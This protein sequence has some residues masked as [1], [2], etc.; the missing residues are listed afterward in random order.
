MIA[1]TVHMVTVRI[2]PMAV[3]I[4]PRGCPPMMRVTIAI[5]FTITLM[6]LLG[7]GA[8][9]HL[10]LQILFVFV[11]FVMLVLRLHF[12]RGEETGGKE[13]ESGEQGFHGANR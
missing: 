11:V 4:I 6:T 5:V 10:I 7:I 8:P 2:N 9:H 1:V 12:G 3:V 13:S